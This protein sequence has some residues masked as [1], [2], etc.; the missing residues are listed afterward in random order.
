MLFVAL[1]LLGCE[2]EP[3]DYFGTTTPRHGPDEIWTNLGAE[4]EWIDP[5]KCSEVSGGTLI[6]NLF[7]G[8]TQPHPGTLAPMPDVARGWDVSADGR[9]YV[10]HLR[11]TQWSDGAPLTAHDFEYAWKRVLDRELASKYASFLYPLKN[12]QAFHT[13]A[14]GDAA[15]VGVRALDELTLQVELEDPLP[16]FLDL[17]SFY[18]AMPVPRH[19][20]EKLERE[21]R[22]PDLWTRPEHIVSNG[23][24]VL[25]EWKFRQSM[26]LR[27]NVRYWD[28]ARVKPAR[29]RLSMVESNNT[30]LNLYEAGELDYIGNSALPAEFIDHLASYR[31]FQRGP[32]LG[33]YFLWVNTRAAP[34]DDVRVREALSLAVDRDSLVRFVTRGGQ[35]PTADLVPDGVAGYRGLGRSRF[36]PDRARRLLR[37]AGYGP[38]RPLPEIVFRYNTSE[39][40]KQIAEAL[41]QMW[42]QHL[43]ADVTIE[44]QEWKVYLKTLQATDFQIARMG[45]IGDYADPF[46]FLELLASGN[47]NNHSNWT[48]PEYDQLLRDANRTQNAEARLALLR[49]AE[50]LAMD[51]VPLIP[52]Y[53]YTRSELV[54]PYLMGH[55]LNYQHRQLF[56]YWWIDRRWY[57]GPQRERRTAPPPPML[58]PELGRLPATDAATH[59][60][61]GTET[62]R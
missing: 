56:K 7:A 36:D 38:D 43:G 18:T 39:G 11:E 59:A 30:T 34:L 58:R 27:K 26:L 9:R 19:V 25:A 54:K 53:V 42:K 37:E 10:F 46:T 20:I 35:D 21:G 60:A 51:A 2:R 61:P 62:A 16:Y 13:G 23:A 29:V 6:F 8:L 12:A 17:V 50:E 44:N 49:R 14:I 45:W 24:F 1:A 31:D 52:I 3:R 41:Q 5:G 22:N 40:H 15:Q 33:T 4:P 57:D 32:Y 48:D 28:A 55:T 47:G